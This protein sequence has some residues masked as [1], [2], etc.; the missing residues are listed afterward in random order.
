MNALRIV[1]ADDHAVVLAGVRAVLERAEPPIEIVGAAQGAEELIALLDRV[2]CDV[3]V[4]DFSMPSP[5]DHG[6]DGLRMLQTIRRTHPLLRVVVLTMLDNP[7]ILRAIREMAHGLISKRSDLR[8]LPAAVAVVGAG[9]SYLSPI[10]QAALESESGRPETALTARET[11]VIRLFADG[12]SVS[13]IARRLNRSVKTISH[14]KADAMRKLG[15]DNHSQL[16][17]YARDHGL[18]S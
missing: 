4:T 5:S 6:Q 9:R 10:L 3:L 14:Q 18:K 11:E 1:L 12:H 17:A 16:Y 13:D 2:P 7:S 8:E 15:I